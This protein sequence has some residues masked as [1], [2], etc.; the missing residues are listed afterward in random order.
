MKKLLVAMLLLATPAFAQQQVKNPVQQKLEA[1][2]GSL[3]VENASLAARNDDLVAQ[4][5]AK[6]AKIKELEGKQEKPSSDS[7]TEKPK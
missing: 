2:L 7:Q 5:A 3:M 4:I 6:D 1:I